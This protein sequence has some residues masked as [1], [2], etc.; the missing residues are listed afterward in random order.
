[1]DFEVLSAYSVCERLCFLGCGNLRIETPVMRSSFESRISNR[2]QAL[3]SPTRV[4]LVFSV[5]LAGR[6]D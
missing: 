4:D 3:V 1:M 2:L 5:R 6:I